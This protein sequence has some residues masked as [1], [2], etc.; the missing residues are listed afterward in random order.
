LLRSITEEECKM[1][2]GA[3]GLIL[4]RQQRLGRALTWSR[5]DALRSA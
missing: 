4:L 1:K 3:I 5:N 2:S